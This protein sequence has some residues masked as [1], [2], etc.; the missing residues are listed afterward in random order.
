MTQHYAVQLLLG[1]LTVQQWAGAL[2]FYYEQKDVKGAVVV[3]RQLVEECK[4][5][6]NNSMIAD[7]KYNMSAFALR[8]LSKYCGI[9]VVT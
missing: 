6:D 5:R 3:W 9:G 7:V 8:W 1:Y 4:A 2:T